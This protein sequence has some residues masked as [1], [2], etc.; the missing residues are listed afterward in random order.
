M[1]KVNKFFIETKGSLYL[2]VVKKEKNI[3]VLTKVL[4][5]SE[6]DQVNNQIKGNNI[7]LNSIGKNLSLSI[8][9][10]RHVVFTIPNVIKVYGEIRP[11]KIND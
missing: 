9:K 7:S 1:A 2:L 11:Y 8:K 4:S 6:D 10:D 3:I 5:R